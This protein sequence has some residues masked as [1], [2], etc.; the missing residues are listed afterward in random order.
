MLL[1]HNKSNM[2]KCGHCKQSGHN[3][4]T[5]PELGH[6]PPNGAAPATHAVQSLTLNAQD[7]EYL[8]T[9]VDMEDI[10][11]ERQRINHR[12]KQCERKNGVLWYPNQEDAGVLLHTALISYPKSSLFLIRAPPGAGKT[13]LIHY[14]YYLLKALLPNESVITGDRITIMTGMSDCDWLN[15]TETALTLLNPYADEKEEIFHNPTLVKRFQQFQENPE[16]LRD[17]VFII[18]ECHVA[19]SKDCTFKGL[20]D[21]IGLSCERTIRRLNIKFI[22]VSATPDMIE[23]ELQQKLLEGEKEGGADELPVFI[24]L[25]PGSDYRGFQYFKDKG[26]I[27]DYRKKLTPDIGA[28]SL[29]TLINERYTTPKV[30]VIRIRGKNSETYKQHIRKMCDKNH[31]VMREHNQK[32]PMDFEKYI[33]DF[34][35][36]SE[37]HTIICIK[38]FYSAGKRL[39]L[40]GHIGV[41]IE[42]SSKTPDITVTAQGLIPRFLGYYSDSDLCF[43]GGEPLFI[44]DLQVI[45]DYLGY[46]NGEPG[47]IRDMKKAYSK[48]IKSGTLKTGR[49]SYIKGPGGVSHRRVSRKFQ[50]WEH[51]GKSLFKDE[52][53]NGEKAKI[54]EYMFKE[55]VTVDD[56]N[57]PFRLKP[58]KFHALLEENKV[59]E[60]GEDQGLY[61]HKNETTHEYLVLKPDDI[62]KGTHTKLAG[63]PAKRD[64]VHSWRAVERV[65]T[66]EVID[67]KKHLR[68]Q[69]WHFDGYEEELV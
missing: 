21:E 26:W 61:R 32:E 59:L 33:N 6:V 52:E 1:T 44:C 42:P 19:S 20:L 40:N 3:R 13:N 9:R 60:E 30:H 54:S 46:C 5:C 68:F 36:V 53:C 48:N 29:E 58:G 16:L 34:D 37:Q 67:G 43:T 23:S 10:E 7:I 56:Q 63:P 18:D 31:W 38:G 64:D 4:R 62:T 50:R 17:H 41:I 57:E 49:A 66:F 27:Q 35:P 28:G 12:K 24:D 14:C 2:G 11:S 45:D 39:R 65:P 55:G 25:V 47:A 69:I 51:D 22:M 8:D 15:Q